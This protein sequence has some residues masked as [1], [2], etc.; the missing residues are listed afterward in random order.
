MKRSYSLAKPLGKDL[1]NCLVWWLAFLRNYTPRPIPT[2]LSSLP[3]LVSYS[4]GEGAD[5]GIG[6]ALWHP[7]ATRPLAVFAEVPA[8]VREQWRVFQNSKS[9]EDIFL[10]EALGPLLLLVTFPRYLRNCLWI[11]FI[12]NSAAEASLIRGASSSTLGDHVVGLTWSLIQKRSIWAYFDRVA[13]KTNPVD[14]LSRKEF[15]GPWEWVRVVPFPIDDLARF[16][17]TLETEEFRLVT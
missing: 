15:R 17:A 6:A 13:S 1:H 12:D 14:G 8:M 10:V 4:D 16:A 9:F 7:F 11:H 2:S 3:L 5:A